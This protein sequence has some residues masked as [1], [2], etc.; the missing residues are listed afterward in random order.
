LFD[1][2]SKKSVTAHK[3]IKVFQENIR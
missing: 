1:A 3:D 2:V